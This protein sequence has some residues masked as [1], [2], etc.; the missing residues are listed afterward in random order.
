[1]TVRAVLPREPAAFARAILPLVL[2]VLAAAVRETR[3]PVLIALAAGTVVALRRDAPVRWAWAA[4]VP[5]ALSLTYGLL[6]PPEVDPL[7]GDCASMVSPLA[8]WRLLEAVLVLGTVGLG[9]ILLRAPGASLW[10][11]RPS[12]RVI[13]LSLL[14]FGVCA[15]AGLVLGPALARPFFGSFGLDASNPWSYL[16]ALVFALSNGIMEEVAYRGALM[17]WSARVTGLGPA[18]VVQAIV[19]GLAHGGPDVIGSGLVLMATLGVG[20]FLAGLVTIRTRSLFLPIA[21][22]VALDLPLYIG[23]ACR[24]P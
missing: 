9:A 4:P 14:G 7:G 18:L 5:V 13:Q 10:L 20:G 12:I 22:H 8:M 3:L 6:V 19:F 2:I 17:G 23:L 21:I 24:V 15:I 11:R 1:V 16:P